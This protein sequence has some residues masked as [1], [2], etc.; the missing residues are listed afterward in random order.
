MAKRHY[1]AFDTKNL[2]PNIQATY[3][4]I[5]NELIRDMNQEL[6]IDLCDHPLYAQLHAYCQ[7]NPPRRK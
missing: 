3:V 2:A 1:I 7:K 6:P 4:E 5:G